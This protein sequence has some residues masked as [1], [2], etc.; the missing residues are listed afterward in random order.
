LFFIKEGIEFVGRFRVANR[1]SPKVGALGDAQYPIQSGTK[2]SPLGKIPA[3]IR[4]K[5]PFMADCWRES[6]Q[7]WMPGAE[8][9]SMQTSNI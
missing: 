6:L 9:W 2:K 7:R 4:L 5:A 8:N 3:E 1:Q